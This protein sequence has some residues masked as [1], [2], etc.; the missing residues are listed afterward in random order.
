MH[1]QADPGDAS[2]FLH[3]QPDRLSGDSSH[4][5][6]V[7]DINNMVQTE[8]TYSSITD[9]EAHLRTVVEAA[10]RADWHAVKNAAADCLRCMPAVASNPEV[11]VKVLVL[12]AEA[13]HRLQQYQEALQVS[14]QQAGLGFL[15]GVH[16]E[17]MLLLYHISHLRQLGEIP[18]HYSHKEP[19][20][21]TAR[22]MLMSWCSCLATRV[23]VR[24]LT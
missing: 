17:G 6:A 1:A 12:Q 15:Q 16:R 20:V 9:E 4:L 2:S 18:C 22:S 3:G 7:P 21:A 11:S 23:A 19:W 10:A 24:H 14:C 8:V 13:Q 5:C